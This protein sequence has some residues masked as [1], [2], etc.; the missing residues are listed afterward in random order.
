M[1]PTPQLSE[2]QEEDNFE[3][4]LMSMSLADDEDENDDDSLV[5]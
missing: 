1:E 4:N 2:G 5:L 3:D